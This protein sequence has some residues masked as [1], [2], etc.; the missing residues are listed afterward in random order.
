[1]QPDPQRRPER[2]ERTTRASSRWLRFPVRFPRPE[3]KE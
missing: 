3:H 2:D 1:V